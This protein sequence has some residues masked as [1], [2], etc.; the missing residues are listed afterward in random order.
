[1]FYLLRDWK[2]IFL[3]L[4]DLLPRGWRA[5]A[6]SIASDIDAVLAEFLRGQVLVMI[7]L[8]CYYAIALAIAGLDRAHLDRDPHR[9]A[10]V[11]SLRRVRARPRARRRRRGA[12]M[13]WLARV[14]GGARRVLASA[15]CWK[16]MC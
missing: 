14:P 8:A 13:A 5:K 4:D 6:R 15:S 3:R 9:A 2:M 16:I 1:M 12:A 11:H 10:G 7:V